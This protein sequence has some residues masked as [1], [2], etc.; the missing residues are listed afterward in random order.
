MGGF[1]SKQ[2]LGPF[3]P[4]ADARR[5]AT[6][7]SRFVCVCVSGPEPEGKGEGD[8]CFSL[9]PPPHFSQSAKALAVPTRET[10]RIMVLFLLPKLPLSGDDYWLSVTLTPT[11]RKENQV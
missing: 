8:V 1:L 11:D 2:R 4:G 3:L 7:I 5:P 9:S 6:A 10:L